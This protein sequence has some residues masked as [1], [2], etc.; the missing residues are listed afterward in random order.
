MRFFAVLF[1][2]L[3]IVAG[4]GY[5]RGWFHVASETVDD[6]VHVDLTVEKEKIRQDEKKAA[7]AVNKLGH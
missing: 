3:L 2:L 6:K 1:V 7:E 5:Y 4:V